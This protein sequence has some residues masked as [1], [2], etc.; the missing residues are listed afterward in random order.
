MMSTSQTNTFTVGC[1]S[2]TTQA[3]AE[4]MK[5]ET[6]ASSSQETFSQSVLQ[7]TIVPEHLRKT[8]DVAEELAKQ[9]FFHGRLNKNDA[10]ALLTRDGQF[11]IRFAKDK[12]DGAVKTVISLL[13]NGRH[14]H[15]LI[16]EKFGLFSVEEQQFESI[17][18]LVQ[19]HVEKRMQ[20]TRATGAIISEAVP[21][22]E[23]IT[24]KDYKL[25]PHVLKA[26]IF[27]GVI[28]ALYGSLLMKRRSKNPE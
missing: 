12:S 27:I 20:L 15:F 7:P 16:R 18:S 21:R 14:Y 5:S 28:F 22:A 10:K 9:Q 13:W 2:S 19:F 25:V 4:T 11:L 6:V 23:P 24:S 26:L 3:T 1:G 17:E 8:D